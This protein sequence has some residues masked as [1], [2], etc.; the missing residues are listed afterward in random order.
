MWNNEKAIKRLIWGVS[1][2]VFFAVAALDR[3]VLPVPFTVPQWVYKLSALNALINATCTVL[4]L[5][6]LYQIKK[7][8]IELHKKINLITFGLSCV[9]LVSYILYHWMAGDTIYPK[10]NPMRWVYYP[11][12][13]THIL[14]AAS[15]LPMILLSFYYGL[16][17]ETEKHRKI[18][19]FAFP[20]WLYV[21]STGVIVYLMISPYYT[22]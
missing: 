14:L 4:L 7:K 12:L 8:N 3:H 13:I 9:F 11:L 18:V 20:I 2:F 5:V 17:M 16:K 10:D 15:V 19:R 6:S 1:I 21:T 22:F